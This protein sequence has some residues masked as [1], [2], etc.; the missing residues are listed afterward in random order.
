MLSCL[1]PGG[2]CEGSQNE[3]AI[4]RSARIS[5]VADP[6]SHSQ[7]GTGNLPVQALTKVGRHQSKDC[8]GE[9]ASFLTRPMR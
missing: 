8:Q 6:Q 9:P 2:A 5:T 3:K 7:R 1:A 4:P